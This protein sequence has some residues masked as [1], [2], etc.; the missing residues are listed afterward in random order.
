VFENFLHN[1]IF[2]PRPE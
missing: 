2:V 1:S